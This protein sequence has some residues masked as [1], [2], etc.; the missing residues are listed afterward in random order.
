MIFILPMPWTFTSV[1][2]IP[3]KSGIPLL[4]YSLDDQGIT[5]SSFASV[6][7]NAVVQVHTAGARKNLKLSQNSSSISN[8][9]KY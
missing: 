9:H 1:V 4:P 6:Q 5:V 2:C 7:R 3:G 8:M